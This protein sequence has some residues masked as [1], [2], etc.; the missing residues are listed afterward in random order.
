M[1]EGNKKAVRFTGLLSGPDG[2]SSPSR[3]DSGFW[4]R[5]G[6]P[7]PHLALS[8]RP[9]S[10]SALERESV[11]TRYTPIPDLDT[12]RS[13]S[14]IE[15][16]PYIPDLASLCSPSPIE[17]RLFIPNLDMVHSPSPIDTHPFIPDLNTVC[18]P[19]PITSH[20]S[21]AVQSPPPI[22]TSMFIPDLNSVRSPS[23]INTRPFIPDLA[24][25]RSPSPI[26]TRPFVPDLSAVRSPS[27]IDTRPFVPDLSAVR[28]P[29]P[30][31]TRPF[32]PDL[33]AVRSP[34]PIESRSQPLATT[35][36]HQIMRLP[37]SSS[38]PLPVSHDSISSFYEQNV[39]FMQNLEQNVL[40]RGMSNMS[41]DSRS[42]EKQR[43][44][45]SYGRVILIMDE[46][47]LFFWSVVKTHWFGPN[48]LPTWR[49]WAKNHQMTVKLMEDLLDY[50][51]RYSS[52]F[53]NYGIDPSCELPTDESG[54]FILPPIEVN[55]EEI[56]PRL[57]FIFTQF[58]KL[59][60]KL[61]YN[62]L[63]QTATIMSEGVEALSQEE[64][65]MSTED[66]EV[67]SDMEFHL[68]NE[69]GRIKNIVDWHESIMRQAD[70]FEHRS[71]EAFVN[72]WSRHLRSAAGVPELRMMETRS[73]APS[74]LTPVCETPYP[75]IPPH[76]STNL[77]YPDDELD[78]T[79][80]L[81]ANMTELSSAIGD[82]RITTSH[83][84]GTTRYDNL[85][86]Q[87]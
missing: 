5:E 58:P 11:G 81:I 3:E 23:P 71:T 20:R 77:R 48:L 68:A 70:V 31:D 25:V 4:Y 84:F 72:A 57:K 78:D 75:D 87:T 45:S 14:P 17:N 1:S 67:M 28:S 27:P 6:G 74:I 73:I 85:A 36:H 8:A 33:S 54:R 64:G 30:I 29:S 26:D 34:S 59:I 10:S 69:L 63:S 32:V 42:S 35:S 2:A 86:R 7:F 46:I 65:T 53:K 56:I 55:S 41:L 61:G 13:P 47:D 16:R 18:S 49:K 15:S 62:E 80:K 22:S 12:M 66:A 9:A 21:S 83:V 38:E 79:E 82:L 43:D 39:R 19:S 52:L 44:Y 76:P 37:S 51:Q 40:I 60:K 50:P 24:A